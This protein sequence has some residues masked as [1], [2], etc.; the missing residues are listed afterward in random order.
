M[1]GSGMSVPL[2]ET[3]VPETGVDDPSEPVDESPLEL[4][5][6]C[7][8]GGSCLIMK[9]GPNFSANEYARLAEVIADGQMR[10]AIG[11]LT[12]APDRLGVDE[13]AQDGFWKVL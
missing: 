7:L 13:G 1:D 4:G 10:C 8:C 2:Q 6:I 11:V 5:D 12:Q 9:R 3:S